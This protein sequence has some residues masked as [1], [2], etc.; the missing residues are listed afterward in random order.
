MGLRRSV[1]VCASLEESAS[2]N[3]T[4]TYI[5][6]ATACMCKIAADSSINSH[7]PGME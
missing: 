1:S 3:L 6:S 7:W 4:F 5:K 2:F